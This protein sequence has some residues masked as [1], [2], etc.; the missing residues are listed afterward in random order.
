VLKISSDS[1]GFSLVPGQ[2]ASEAWATDVVK[3]S[4]KADSETQSPFVIEL[5]LF[6]PNLP[7]HRGD[8]G[9]IGSV[10][11]HVDKIHLI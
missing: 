8:Q 9:R 6:V 3:A 7:S 1:S 10:L 2:Q 11:V 4:A 5:S